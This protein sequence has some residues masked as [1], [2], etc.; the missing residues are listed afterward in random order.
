MFWFWNEC[1]RTSVKSCVRC[2]APDP[3]DYVDY[4]VL[5]PVTVSQPRTAALTPFAV[6][7][8]DKEAV[9]RNQHLVQTSARIHDSASAVEADL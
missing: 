7:K 2:R 4:D 5:T 1:F 8:T 3:T 9:W 6:P